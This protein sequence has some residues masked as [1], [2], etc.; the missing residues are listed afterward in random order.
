MF[1]RAVVHLRW[2]RRRVGRRSQPLHWSLNQTYEAISS[3]S[4]DSIWKKMMDLADMSWHPLIA[5]TNVP[6]GIVAKPGLIFK[7]VNRL[8][9]LPFRVFVERVKPGEFLSVRICAVPGVEERVTYRLE[10]KV[11]GTCISYSVMMRG[12]LSPLVWSLI[13]GHAAK[14]AE[15]LANAAETESLQSVSGYLRSPKNTCLDF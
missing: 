6:Y 4:V 5:K 8:I 12:W 9:P 2:L 7:A 3:A 15:Q 11:C 14:V 10:S 13:R 1:R